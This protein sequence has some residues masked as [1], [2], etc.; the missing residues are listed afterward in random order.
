VRFIAAAGT[1]EFAKR[2]SPKEGDVISF[3]HSGFLLASKKPKNPLVYRLRTDLSWPDV[4][5][6]FKEQTW[7]PSG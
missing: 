7:Q 2:W 4:V 5:Q 6:S 3:K 1:G